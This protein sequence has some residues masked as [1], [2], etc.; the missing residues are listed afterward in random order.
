[1]VQS[2]HWNSSR[3]RRL[4]QIEVAITIKRKTGVILVRF[5]NF[6]FCDAQKELIVSTKVVETTRSSVAS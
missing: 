1:M 3:R 4:L 2:Y 6:N 5:A